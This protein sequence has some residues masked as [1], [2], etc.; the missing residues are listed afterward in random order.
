MLSKEKAGVRLREMFV[1]EGI[2]E[3]GFL[4]LKGYFSIC[5]IIL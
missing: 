2:A 5:L 4:T 3:D 1:S